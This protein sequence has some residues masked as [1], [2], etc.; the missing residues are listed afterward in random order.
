MCVSHPGVTRLLTGPQ[1][2]DIVSVVS[3]SLPCEVLWV[4]CREGPQVFWTLW[5]IPIALSSSFHLLFLFLCCFSLESR[6]VLLYVLL[7]PALFPCSSSSTPVVL[8]YNI[9]TQAGVCG[10]SKPRR[11]M[12]SYS[13]QRRELQW[14]HIC[15]FGMFQTLTTAHKLYKKA[16]KTR[17]FYHPPLP[18]S[19]QQCEQGDLTRSV[20]PNLLSASAWTVRNGSALNPRTPR[21]SGME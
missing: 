13:S 2:E 17:F 12:L 7:H 6:L 11:P 9:L 1:V 5:P 18:G 20:F 14:K 21:I 4:I 19:P 16:R 15:C 3:R 8:L 10:F